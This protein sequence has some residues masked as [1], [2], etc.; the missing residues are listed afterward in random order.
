LSRGSQAAA[1]APATAA[2][3]YYRFVSID[4]PDSIEALAYGIS[5]AGVVTGTYLDANNVPHGFVWR[6]GTLQ[7]LDNPT[8]PYT[9]L[10]AGS[11]DV[12]AGYYGDPTTVTAATYSFASG[13]WNAFP[14]ISG[15]PV[16]QGYGINRSGVAVGVAGGGV[17]DGPSDITSWIWDP[18]S[19]SYTFFAVPGAEQSSTDVLG[20]NDLGQIVG[21]YADASGVTHGFLKEGDNYTTFDPPDSIFTIAYQ[22]NNSDVIVGFFVNLAGW[23]EGFVRTSDGKFDVVNFPGGLETQIGAINDRGDISGYWVDPNTGFWTAFVG[24]RQ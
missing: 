21:S 17:F 18:G 12:V 6:N 10:S 8:A 20:I 16:N 4:I 9:A 7:T 22:I 23:D 15:A 11:K 14:A 2:S 1:P 5:D 13:A 24:Y 3:A 19:Q